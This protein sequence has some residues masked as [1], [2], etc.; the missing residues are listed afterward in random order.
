MRLFRTTSRTTQASA[1]V[2]I[3]THTVCPWHASHQAALV[4]FSFWKG[5]LFLNFLILFTREQRFGN[6]LALGQP[7][8]VFVMWFCVEKRDKYFFCFNTTLVDL[9]KKST[10]GAQRLAALFQH[11]TPSN[12]SIGCVTAPPINSATNP[13]IIKGAAATKCL[14]YTPYHFF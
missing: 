10:N 6:Q 5:V 7:A 2:H 1:A 13:S 11:E 9:L 8:S 4:V 3:Y 12:L 14:L